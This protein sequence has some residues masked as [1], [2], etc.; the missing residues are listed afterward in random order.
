MEGHQGSKKHLP[1]RGAAGAG[2]VR[3]GER[4]DSGG[5]D[6]NLP[7]PIRRLWSICSQGLHSAAQWESDTQ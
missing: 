6:S 5:P 2:L 1:L 3:S 4:K 7:V